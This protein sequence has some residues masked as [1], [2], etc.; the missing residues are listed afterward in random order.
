GLLELSGAR[1]RFRQPQPSHLPVQ[2][3]ARTID[4]RLIGLD[5]LRG[6]AERELQR[7]FLIPGEQ[8]RIGRWIRI[9]RGLELYNRRLRALA[10]RGER[11]AALSCGGA[12]RTYWCVLNDHRV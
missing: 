11:Q 1:I 3:V 7:G 8:S 12:R 2:A 5:G 6:V 10:F 9:C 4:D